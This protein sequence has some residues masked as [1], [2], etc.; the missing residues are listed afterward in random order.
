VAALLQDPSEKQQ[1]TKIHPL[2]GQKRPHSPPIQS[3]GQQQESNGRNDFVPAAPLLQN[4]IVIHLFN[5]FCT[6]NT[7]Y[8]N[9]ITS[10]NCL[11]R[12]QC[13]KSK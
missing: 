7:I 4:R 11:I 13:H 6:K 2:L 3:L 12:R 9:M 1:T 8:S 10:E 5:L